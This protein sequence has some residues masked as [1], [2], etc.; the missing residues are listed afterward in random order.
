MVLLW[1]SSNYRFFFGVVFKNVYDFKSLKVV[2][3]YSF[4]LLWI[5]YTTM[6]VYLLLYF[7]IDISLIITQKKIGISPLMLVLGPLRL[8]RSL[9]E[10]RHLGTTSQ[11]LLLR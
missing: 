10:R 4:L 11:W 3:L 7:F 2:F 1:V 8:P 5:I 6:N 9:T